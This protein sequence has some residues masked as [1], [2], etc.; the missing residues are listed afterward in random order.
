M[1]SLD[2]ILPLVPRDTQRTV[3]RDTLRIHQISPAERLAKLDEQQLDGGGYGAAGDGNDGQAEQ[4]A[5]PESQIP[6][7]E[8]TDNELEPTKGNHI[9]TFV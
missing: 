6:Q 7:P 2:A 5:S 1:P 9:D 3:T 4:Q 8:T